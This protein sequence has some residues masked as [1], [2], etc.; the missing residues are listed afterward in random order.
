M[1]VATEVNIAP[2]ASVAATGTSSRDE[3]LPPESQAS[4]STVSRF[5]IDA[6]VVNEHSSKQTTKR[7]VRSVREHVNK[8][9][10]PSPILESNSPRDLGKKGVV[11][12]SAHIQTWVDPCPT[13]AHQD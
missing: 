12:A 5:D 11:T 3:F 9:T 13:L 7:F 1:K 8:P 4:I 6:S 2:F 10:L